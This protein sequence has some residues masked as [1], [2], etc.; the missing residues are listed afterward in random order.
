MNRQ[1]T[2]SLALFSSVHKLDL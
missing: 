2:V 1:L